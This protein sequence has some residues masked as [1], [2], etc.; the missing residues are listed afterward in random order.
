MTTSENCTLGNF[1][2]DPLFFF[3]ISKFGRCTSVRMCV[4]VN[5]KVE[6]KVVRQNAFR[7]KFNDNFNSFD[8]VETTNRSIIIK[9]RII[10]YERT[11]RLLIY[12]RA[13]ISEWTRKVGSLLWR[14]WH[15]LFILFSSQR[16]N[17]PSIDWIFL[18]FFFLVP[19]SFLPLVKC[20]DDFSIFQ[21][22]L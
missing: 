19:F 5:A 1:I 14:Q 16:R 18:V 22:D 9:L 3:S 4:S 12:T 17:Y 7:A 13:S 8:D 21:T 2:F 20:I 10:S 15:F 11:L 6:E